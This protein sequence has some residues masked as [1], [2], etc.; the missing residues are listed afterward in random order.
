MTVR[1][2]G[3]CWDHP[4]CVEPM[5]AAAAAYRLVRPDVVLEWDARPLARFNDQPVWEVDGYDLIFM[6][7]PMVGA[8]AERAALVPLDSV[9]DL[10]RVTAE[11]VR[12]D[13]YTWDGRHWALGVDAACQVAAYRADRLDTVPTTWDDVLELAR[14]EPGAVALP[15]YPSDAICALMSLSANACM[16]DGE[17][18]RW[19]H[20]AGA[21]MLVELAGLVDPV[22]FD[23]NPPALLAA[24]ADGRAVYVPFVFGYA[25]LSRGP[26]RFADVA[27]VD[28]KPRGAVLGG[29]GLA[30]FPASAHVGEAAAFAAWCMGTDVQREVL[31]EAGGQPGNRLVWDDPTA[32]EVTGGFLSATRHTIDA[33]YLRPRDAWWP[34]F[35]RDGGQL[36]A[37]LLRDGTTPGRVV[38][39]LSGL[40]EE[41]HR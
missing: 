33:A 39:E 1:L 31:L 28:G 6:D 34:D 21:A 17:S 3:L 40:A 2:R 8:V 16:A 11:A 15:L 12:G 19:L 5:K 13:A 27:G 35:Q 26:L 36:L 30:V 41:A 14:S 22:C 7:H 37:R 32:D 38:E 4:R 9:V 24:M 20:P 25:N 10:G 29:A 23:Q 18:P